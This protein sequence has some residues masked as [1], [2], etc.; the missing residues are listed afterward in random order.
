M[1]FAEAWY[2]GYFFEK[3]PDIH[4]VGSTPWIY[5][6]IA[7]AVI[8]YLFG[9]INCSVLLSKLYGT[10]IRNHGSGNAGATN[11]TRTFGKKA[12]I[13]TFLGDFLKTVLALFACRMIMGTEGVFIAG[14]F[15]ILGHAYPLF[16]K[17]KGGKGVV[18]MAACVL[19]AEPFVFLT[20][21]VIFVIILFCFK[22]VSLASVMC[23]VIYP[24]M[25]NLVPRLM[26]GA[27][28]YGIHIIYAMVSALLVIFLHRKNI[29]RIFNHT[30]PKI[31]DKNKN[32]DYE[33]CEE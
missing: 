28:F 10:D 31:N 30:E 9:S 5:A 23:M 11:M 14:I 18:C 4:S 7:C 29:V 20:M 8:A 19:F 21:L 24:Y 25:L 12:G 32:L 6:A 2:L 26:F 16:F 15:C 3:Y 13:L 22:M 17:F 1:S 27:D 33:E